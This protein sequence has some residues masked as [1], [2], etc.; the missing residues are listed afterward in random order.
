MSFRLLPA[1]AEQVRLA[2]DRQADRREQVA[3]APDNSTQAR[4]CRPLQQLAEAWAEESR[5]PGTG[6]ATK[7][8]EPEVHSTWAR[9]S[10]LPETT[11][12]RLEAESL[13]RANRDRR[14]EF[15]TAPAEERSRCLPKEPQRADLGAAEEEPALGVET[16]QA[17]DSP[18]EA[19]VP[20]KREL[21]ADRTRMRE[22]EFL[23]IQVPEE[24]EAERAARRLCQE[25]L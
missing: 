17:A 18:A 2:E 14:W 8:R 10:H 19:R 20:Q 13:F 21:A 6:A 7:A 11:A 4:S 15:P 24:R 16:A 3:A 9:R 1:S 5:R 25:S 12:M 22:A 23:R